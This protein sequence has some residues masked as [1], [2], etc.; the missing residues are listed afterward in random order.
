MGFTKMWKV[1][2]AETPR[3]WNPHVIT[4]EWDKLP[5]DTPSCLS[6]IANW[7]AGCPGGHP[8]V[9]KYFSGL[10][11]GLLFDSYRLSRIN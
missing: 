7:K 3:L 9:V 11:W 6:P 2:L 4:K 10:L 5:T 8:R 1:G